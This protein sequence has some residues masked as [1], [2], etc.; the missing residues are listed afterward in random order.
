MN[1]AEFDTFAE[2]YRALHQSNITASGE[3][4][5]YFAEYKLRDLKRVIGDDGRGEE[6]LRILDFGAG[7]GTAVPYFRKHLPS[8]QLTCVDVSVKSLEMGKTR[9][10]GQAMFVA[11]DGV[12]LPFPEK[13]FD[14]A[15]AACVFHHILPEQHFQILA[16]LHRVLTPGGQLMIYEHNPLNPLTVAAVNSCEFDD[17]AILLHSKALRKDLLM[18]GF[19][20]AKIRYRVFFPRVLRWLRWAEAGL[21][22]LPLGAQYFVCGRR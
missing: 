4:P 8:A 16:E 1:R 10:N 14:Y 2:N 20:A 19:S 5:E 22:W 18:A 17:N 12:G 21:G 15:F 6:A 11:F 9:F 13:H 7:I 3:T